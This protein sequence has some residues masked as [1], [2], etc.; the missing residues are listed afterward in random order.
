[1]VLNCL[2]ALGC[3]SCR[4]RFETFKN[5]NSA[6]GTVQER[7]AAANLL[8]TTEN[9]ATGSCKVRDI[10][11]EDTEMKNCCKMHGYLNKK[12]AF[13]SS[14]IH[15]ECGGHTRAQKEGQQIV[16]RQMCVCTKIKRCTF[17]F[18]EGCSGVGKHAVSHFELGL[19]TLMGDTLQQKRAFSSSQQPQFSDTS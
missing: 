11:D 3:S 15:Y 2:V 1:M 7:F 17:F 6:Q 4:S 13:R 12:T 19:G 18:Y 9:E 14:E 5:R 8:R 10:L 16:S